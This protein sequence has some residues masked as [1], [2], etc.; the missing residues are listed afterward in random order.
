MFGHLTTYMKGLTIFSQ[1]IWQGSEWRPWMLL[2]LR[3]THMWWACNFTKINTPPWVL[4]TIF[5]LYKWYQIA[6]RITYL[7][8]CICD[9]LPDLVSFVQLKKRE[10]HR[11]RKP[12]TLLKV[13]PPY[14]CFL[15]C[16]NGTK[17]GK[18]SHISFFQ[19]RYS[20]DSL[21]MPMLLFHQLCWKLCRRICVPCT[22]LTT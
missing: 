2:V 15:N 18:A 5:K 8:N 7:T 1:N 9:G 4:F 13:K 3:E 16:T 14:E 22:L 20:K 12:A 19:L 11:Q 17:L 10:K 6:Q 21:F